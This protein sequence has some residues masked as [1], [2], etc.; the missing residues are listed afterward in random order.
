VCGEYYVLLNTDLLLH[1]NVL[2]IFAEVFFRFFE[3]HQ[4]D[5]ATTPVLL[6]VPGNNVI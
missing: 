5:V 6:M 4:K 1:F 3:I 2:T